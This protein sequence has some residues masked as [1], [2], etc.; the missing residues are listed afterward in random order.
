M[1]RFLYVIWDADP[2][3]NLDKIAQHRLAPEEVED[4]L[5]DLSLSPEVS[6]SSGEALLKGFTRTGRYIAVPYIEVDEDTAY[7]LTA[8]DI[9][10]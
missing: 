3:R 7:P 6:R 9:E 10:D 2:G 8:F 4:V 5:Q 1:P